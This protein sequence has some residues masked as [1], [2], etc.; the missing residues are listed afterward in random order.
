MSELGKVTPEQVE[1]FENVTREHPELIGQVLSSAIE[2]G[3]LELPNTGEGISTQDLREKLY[4][5]QVPHEE[6]E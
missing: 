5:E 4:K 3:L 1:Q 6:R 2:S